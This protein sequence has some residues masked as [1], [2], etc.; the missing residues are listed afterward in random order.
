MVLTRAPALSAALA[1]ARARWRERG[2]FLVLPTREAAAQAL[3][4]ECGE[5]GVALDREALTFA[6]LR[7][8]IAAAAGIAEPRPPA[9]IEVRLALREAL[10]RVDLTAFGAAAGSPGFLSAVERAV[11]E[12]REARVTPERVTGAARGPIA[13]ALAAVHAAAWEAVPHA[14]D[15]LWEAAA[16][17]RGLAGFPPVTVAGFDDLVP[18]Q[19]ELLRAVGAVTPVEVVV[20]FA[21]GRSAFEARGARVARWEA[22]L[23][24]AAVDAPAE[25]PRALARRLFDAGPPMSETL[26]LRLVGAAGTAGMLR[27]ALDEALDAAAGGVPLSRIALVVPRLSELRD[28]LDRLLADWGV[29]ARRASR[30]RVLEAPVVLAL[31]HLLELGER[32]PDDPGALDH[33]LGWLRTPYSGAEPGEIDLFEA[34][35]RGARLG[36]RGELMRRWE[37]PAIAPARRLVAAARQGPRAQIAALLDLGG[38]ALRRAGGGGVP[39]RADLRDREALAA[40]A[41]IARALTDE[42]GADEPGSQARGPL[43]PGAL[44]AIVAD[45][46]VVAREDDPGGIDLHDLTSLRGHL[47]DVVV[48]SGLDGEGYPGRPAADPLL[49]DLREPL[50]DV[51]PPRAP[52]TSE[53]RLRFTHA[54]DAAATALRLVRRVVD[55][56]GREVAPSPYWIEVCRL[57]GREIDVLDRRTGARGE[58]ADGAE[59][60]RTGR[61]ALRALALERAVV[62]GPLAEAAGRRRRPVGVP[63]GAFLDR[64]R[65]RVTEVESY[66]RCAYGWFH[67][68]VIAPHPLESALDAAFEGSLGHSALQRTY[69]RMRDEKVGGCTPATLDRYRAA[70]DAAMAD[71]AAKEP[72]AGTGSA[73]DAAVERLRR[74]LSA[75]LGREA[76]LGSRLVPTEF[77][78]RMEDGVLVGGGVVISGQLDRLDVSPAGDAALVVDYKRSGASFEAASED[79]TKRL[80]L[81]LYGRM[82]QDTL[83]S[84]AEPIGGLYMGMLKPSIHGA[85]RDDVPGAPAVAG[86]SAERWEQITEEAVAAVRDAVA[87]IHRGEIAPPPASPCTPWC[88]CGDL[89]R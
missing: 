31:T 34:A 53:S 39:S 76:A 38:E 70:L 33:L 88:R 74:H 16:A 62:P 68:N 78:Q 37:G 58:V 32:E 61:E 28:E 52:G 45:L 48:I 23:A 20:P 24:T 86:V 12:L 89:W 56:N 46:T 82:A 85:V 63:P 54:V 18:G 59:A 3:L 84:A 66:L 64:R 43:P 49:A 4:A 71:A 65:F 14:S 67:A 44:G 7:G 10:D 1:H 81:P 29:P 22:G 26:D 8:R 41:G 60:A 17:A 11:G 25:G 75:M 42:P 69:E 87:R 30:M 57:T 73:Y 36:G 77:E 21:P 6:A 72:P 9:R 50:R 35:A 27:A 15:A 80:Q 2:G 55:D 47:Y 83:L 5:G 13:T 79:V 19:W 40:L 51:L